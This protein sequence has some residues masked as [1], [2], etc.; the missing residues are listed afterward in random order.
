MYIFDLQERLKNELVFFSWAGYP[1]WPGIVI[2]PM[3]NLAVW[4]FFHLTARR[5]INGRN[6]EKKTITQGMYMHIYIYRY[7]YVC[8][9]YL[10]QG[11]FAPI[12]AQQLFLNFLTF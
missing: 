8:F 2:A 10:G 5:G 4:L 1:R 12:L 7:I 6:D 3:E 9:L 11:G